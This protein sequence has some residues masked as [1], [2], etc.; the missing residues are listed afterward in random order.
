MLSTLDKQTHKEKDQPFSLSL[1]IRFW[2]RKVVMAALHFRDGGSDSRWGSRGFALLLFLFFIYPLLYYLCEFV[3]ATLPSCLFKRNKKSSLYR[4]C[5]FVPLYMEYLQRMRQC[6]YFFSPTLSP[7]ILPLFFFF[8]LTLG[9]TW[10]YETPETFSF[11]FSYFF[12]CD[13]VAPLTAETQET[14]SPQPTQQ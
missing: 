12:F 4:R 7:S 11:F 3:T 13:S 9:N 1:P 5:R 2:R 8:F 10:L 14:T 6:H